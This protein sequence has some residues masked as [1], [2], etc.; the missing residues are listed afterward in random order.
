MNAKLRSRLLERGYFPAQLPPP[1]VTATLAANA[2]LVEK[3]L[4]ASKTHESEC[5]TFSVARVAHRRRTVRIPNPISQLILVTSISQHWAELRKHY[6]R[7]R[8]TV[9][10][11][12]AMSRSP[13]RAIEI[14]MFGAL[15][16]ER[17]QR[18]A[19]YRYALIS[20]ITQFFPSIY[21]HSLPWAIEGR[22]V[23]KSKMR[24]KKKLGYG[25]D[26]DIHVRNCQSKQTKGLP[27]GPDTSHILAEV[28][29]VGIDLKVRD[30]FGR[31]PAG[32]RYVD[33]YALFFAT[34][35]DADLALSCLNEAV[36]EYE[37]VL[38]EH[39][40]RIATLDAIEL[41]LWVHELRQFPFSHT[42][43]RQTAEVHH[44]FHIA[45]TRA[46]Q[47]P[48][49]SVMK[50][51]LK[52]IATE[53]IRPDSWPVFE[54]YL[55][56]TAIAYPDTLQ[57]VSQFLLTYREAGYGIDKIAL[58]RMLESILLEHAM[59]GHHFETAWCLWIAID[60]SV[61]MPVRILRSITEQE[62]SICAL[63]ALDL[64]SRGL[65]NGR[66]SQSAWKSRCSADNL[67]GPHWLLAYQ[68][69]RDGFFPGHPS[70]VASDPIWGPL[71]ARGVT[72]Y[73]RGRK[74]SALF[75]IVAPDKSRTEVLDME[76]NPNEF[77]EF[78][79]VDEEY[80]DR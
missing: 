55:L 72:F 52:R 46:A 14:P 17:A 59:R 50:F 33:D 62:S 49:E 31:W 51:A 47:F 20:D 16:S 39:K 10:R 13:G 57:L 21:T 3:E 35:N 80:I 7:S 34:R 44:F 58:R 74:Q 70:F 68:S 43:S 2:D 15:E 32:Y 76:G 6:T 5:E 27:I 42:R 48:N 66:I 30:Q 1:F 22:S 24:A 73:D 19:G 9:S 11:P 25:N 12:K 75:N 29:G 60:N 56:R 38:N 69:E 67:N 37:L 64:S 63:L 78:V 4:A 28:V 23:V 26:L 40:T 45:L 41:D 36:S 77:L 79:D 71:L 53:L 61:E 18:S 65:C 54:A 8:I